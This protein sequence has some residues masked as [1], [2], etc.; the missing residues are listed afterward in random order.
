MLVSSL[1]R[2]KRTPD[3]SKRQTLIVTK[4]AKA[5]S[6]QSFKQQ[7]NMKSSFNP[8]ATNPGL[9]FECHLLKHI[10]K[11][12]SPHVHKQRKLVTLLDT[13]PRYWL[14]WYML[15]LQWTS[16][17]ITV[18]NPRSLLDLTSSEPLASSLYVLSSTDTAMHKTSN[19]TRSHARMP[20]TQQ[21]NLTKIKGSSTE[22]QQKQ[23]PFFRDRCA[24][25]MH[26]PFRSIERTTLAQVSL[27]VS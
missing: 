24:S 26:Q 2:F 17:S 16:L 19:P 14:P 20:L 11:S 23:N 25:M 8:L 3:R 12:S 22:V 13:I 5:K 4:P 9:L 15:Q 21:E 18:L 1:G 7:A 6:E 27:D 10:S